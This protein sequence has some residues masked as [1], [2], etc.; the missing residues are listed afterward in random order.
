LI[1]LR[2]YGLLFLLEQQALLVKLHVFLLLILF[3][4]ESLIFIY[5]HFKISFL[6]AP[7]TTCR[8]TGQLLFRLGVLLIGDL[9]RRWL[10]LI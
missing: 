8:L 10:L 7:T 2:E 3:L 9:P 6:P 4:T 5:I 1:P